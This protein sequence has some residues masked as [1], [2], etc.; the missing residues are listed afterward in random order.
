M[1]QFF[2]KPSLLILVMTIFTAVAF[3]SCD[4]L[5]DKAKD[6]AE[7]AL[8]SDVTAKCEGSYNAS[9]IGLDDYGFRFCDNYTQ[10]TDLRSAE[11]D[12]GTLP[13]TKYTADATCNK[14]DALAKCEVTTV[15]KVK[16]TKY[17]YVS[18]GSYDPSEFSTVN[19]AL[20]KHCE[21]VLGKLGD[22]EYTFLAEKE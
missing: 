2:K 17:Y 18:S 7:D 15:D 10:E 9:V 21:D 1:K 14:A 5:L 11:D 12:C 16:Y 4:D 19:S 20:E 8:T 22:A 6:A 3:T 13:G